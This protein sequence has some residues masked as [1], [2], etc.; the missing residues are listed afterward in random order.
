MHPGSE[1]NKEIPD[2]VGRARSGLSRIGKPILRFLTP[3]LY[4]KCPIQTWPAWMAHLHDVSVPRAVEAQS[5]PAPTGGANINIIFRMIDRTRS[6]NGDLADCGVFRGASLVA[7]AIYLREQNIVKTVY[8]FDSFHGFDDAVKYDIE[9]RGAP[10]GRKFVGGFSDTSLGL[11]LQKAKRFGLENIRLAPG[12]FRDSFARQPRDL[13]FC[14]VHLDVNLYS[15]YKECMQ[16]FYPRVVAGGIILLDEYN[17]PSWPGCNKA[18]DEFLADKPERLEAIV[19]D[20][21]QK[22]YLIKQ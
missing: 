11:V 6:L 15:S 20:N 4:R 16:F 21:Y 17:D 12:Y 14:F 2:Y 3:P 18:M 5:E 22:Y 7:I 8:G 13:R 1:V 19:S 10:A 9:L